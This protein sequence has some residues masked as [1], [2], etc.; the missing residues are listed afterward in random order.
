MEQNEFLKHFLPAQR[1]LWAYLQAATRD[2]NETDDLLQEVSN[3]LWEK[4]DHYD[5]A[6]PFTA[7]ALGVARLQIL[8]WLQSK[9]RGRRILSDESL[10]ALAEAAAQ[11]VEEPDPRP[12]LLSGC[13]AALQERARKVIEMKYAGGLPIKEIADRLGQQVGAIEMALV[14]ARRALRQCIERKMKYA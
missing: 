2:V 6:R 10:T 1:S 3:V 8:K 7:W 5:P 13:I 4:F 11:S 12:A 14:R 9:A